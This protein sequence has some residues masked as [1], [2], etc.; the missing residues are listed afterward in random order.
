MLAG[1]LLDTKQL[2]HNNQTLFVTIDLYR[3]IPGRGFGSRSA[4]RSP[5]ELADSVPIDIKHV[6]SSRPYQKGSIKNTIG[7]VVNRLVGMALKE[8][9]IKFRGNLN[10]SGI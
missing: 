4:L 7:V 6:Y 2:C 3:A 10:T 8:F 9:D 5:I 1:Y